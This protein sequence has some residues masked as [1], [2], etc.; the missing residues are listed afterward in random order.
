M[1]YK[2]FN[3][4]DFIS[5]KNFQNWIVHPNENSNDF[6]NTWL[7][8]NPEKRKTID[9]ARSVLLNI[10]FKEDFPDNEDVESA[11]QKLLHRIQQSSE[12]DHAKRSYSLGNRLRRIAAVFIGLIIISASLFYYNWRFAKI[13]ES[14]KYGEMKTIILPD[15]SKVILNSNSS[16]TFLKH[17][18]THETREVTLKGEGF[19]VVNHLNRNTGKI[20]PNER[21]MVHG[22]AVTVE[23]LGTAFD[24]RQ[25]RGETEVVLQRGSIKLKFNNSSKS[26][27]IMRP[28]EI[29]TYDPTAKKMI[30]ATTVPENYS[31]WKEKKLI[32]NDPTLEQ[33]ANYLEDNYGKKIIIEDTSLKERKIEGPILLNN[34]DDALFIISTVLNTDIQ[35][36]D[37]VLLIRARKTPE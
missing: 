18:P 29:I 3:V 24:I 9:E 28:G 23:V 10:R 31:A 37:N 33:I 30:V 19:F 15:S 34:L 2:N 14:S 5:D 26:E 13:T 21:F 1:D 22:E 12:E 17:W 27:T 4:L 6:W 36:K 8:K 7:M 32:L 16:I 20:S 35:K 25:R 11:L